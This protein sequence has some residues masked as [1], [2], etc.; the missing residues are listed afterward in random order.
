MIRKYKC[1]KCTKTFAW[2]DD[3]LDALSVFHA[4]E[5][6]GSISEVVTSSTTVHTTAAFMS[7]MQLDSMHDSIH[8][9]ESEAIRDAEWQRETKQVDDAKKKM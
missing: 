7:E 9:A 6:D 3:E 2:F 4:M 8:E 5:C 1:S